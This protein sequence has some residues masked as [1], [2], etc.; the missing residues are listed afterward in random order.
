MRSILFRSTILHISP[1]WYDI[2]HFWHKPLWLWFWFNLKGLIPRDIII[3]TY[4][5]M[6]NLFSNQRSSPWIEYHICWGRNDH[7]YITNET[8]FHWYE[9]FWVKLKEKPW[10][11]FIP[12]VNNSI[13]MWSYVEGLWPRHI[14]SSDLRCLS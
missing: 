14:H 5:P 1:H 6:L 8:Y 3:F 10:G 9:A 11:T 13:S 4:I 2:V 12:K 7:E